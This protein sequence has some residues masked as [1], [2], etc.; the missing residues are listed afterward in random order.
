M[1]TGTDSGPS[2]PEIALFFF[3]FQ[4]S[5]DACSCSWD[6]CHL[7]LIKA[8]VQRWVFKGHFFMPVTFS[9]SKQPPLS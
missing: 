7:E 9:F 6:H 2:H 4:L 8:A 3:S 5:A 1:E